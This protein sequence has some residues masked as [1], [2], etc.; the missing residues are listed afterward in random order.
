MEEER[1]ARV[2]IGGSLSELEAN[3]VEDRSLNDLKDVYLKESFLLLAD[4][5]EAK[6][7]KG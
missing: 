6:R 7:E 1:A 5:I 2:K 3:K 4:Q